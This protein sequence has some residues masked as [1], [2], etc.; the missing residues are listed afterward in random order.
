MTTFRNVAFALVAAALLATAAGIAGIADSYAAPA[1]GAPA[2]PADP[3][4]ADKTAAANQI[5]TLITETAAK[6]ASL[7]QIIAKQDAR[8][9]PYS[10]LNLQ[11]IR[12]SLAALR[13]AKADA[14]KAT[15]KD[16]IKAALA[17]AEGVKKTNAALAEAIEKGKMGGDALAKGTDVIDT[18]NDNP[19][20]VESGSIPGAKSNDQRANGEEFAD[21]SFSDQSKFG[22]EQRS[23]REAGSDG[24]FAD[25]SADSL[26]DSSESSTSLGGNTTLVDGTNPAKPDEKLPLPACQGTRIDPTKCQ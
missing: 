6:A 17:K 23:G 25:A 22:A 10:R 21:V 2:A 1:A 9:Q 14:E 4:A 13:E 11:K 15:S 8:T 24:A 16:Q 19:Q 18:L 5:Q 26:P 3:L 12:D 20:L 7:E